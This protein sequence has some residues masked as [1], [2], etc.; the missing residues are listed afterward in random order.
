MASRPLVLVLDD[1]HWADP[2]SVDALAALIRRPPSAPVLLAL[3]AREGQVPPALA[4]AFGGALRLA[5]LSEAEA[6]ELIGDPALYARAGGNPFYL[7]QLARAPRAASA[8]AA[9]VPAAVAAAIGAELATLSTDARRLLD[10]AAVAGDP[11]ELELADEVAELSAAAGLEALDELLARALVRPTAVPRRFAFR[12]PVVRHAV[13]VAAPAGWRLGAHARAAD[14]LGRRGAGAVQRAHHVQYAARAGDERAIALLAEAASALQA[15][16][17]GTAAH[18]TPRSCGCS[19]TTASAGS[20][21]SPGS[22]TR[23][24]PRARPRRPARRWSTPCATPRP[25][26]ASDSR[27]RWPTRTG[28]SAA[29]TTRAAGC[30]SPSVTCPRNRPRTASAC[31]CARADRAQRLRPARRPGPDQRRP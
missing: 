28:G 29:T 7:E 17:P 5:P 9:D 25:A 6:G 21:R 19:P 2:A 15:S 31:G 30:T 11:F 10:A 1:V 22:P 18:F 24:P 20:R 23:S 26:S 13:Y 4:S 16:A 14:V 12:H 3:A 27:S 8:P